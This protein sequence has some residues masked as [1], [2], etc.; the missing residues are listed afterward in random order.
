MLRVREIQRDNITGQNR[1][2]GGRYDLAPVIARVDGVIE[3]A[4]RAARPNFHAIGGNRAEYHRAIFNL[5]RLGRIFRFRQ[6]A[7]ISCTAL[8]RMMSI[9]RRSPAAPTS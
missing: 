4:R 3:L 7:S 9:S 6:R 1:S 8:L 2:A 5:V